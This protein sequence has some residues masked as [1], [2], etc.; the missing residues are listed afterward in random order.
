[1]PNGWEAFKWIAGFVLLVVVIIV[2]YRLL[3]HLITKM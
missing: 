2:S 1:M 3:D